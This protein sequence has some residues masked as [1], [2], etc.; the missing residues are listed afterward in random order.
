MRITALIAAVAFL[1]ALA[2]ADSFDTGLGKVARTVEVEADGHL[3]ITGVGVGNVARTGQVSATL[4]VDGERCA[5]S[6]AHGTGRL[7]AMTSCLIAVKAGDRPEIEL[8]EAHDYGF[9]R[10][11]TLST[12][13]IADPTAPVT[14]LGQAQAEREASFTI[15]VA[16]DTP[17]AVAGLVDIAWGSC[18]DCPA[19]RTGIGSIEA[20]HDAGGEGWQTCFSETF[21]RFEEPANKLGCT[22]TAPAGR[23]V[24]VHM[25]LHTADGASIGRAILSAMT[26]GAPSS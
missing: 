1:P 18:E 8:T 5:R 9:S 14:P 13:M 7:H 26:E 15:E 20:V 16:E 10:R 6:I 22:F 4:T 24:T 3:L 19:G 21:N 23:A 25:L 2:A 11:S 12:R 17:V